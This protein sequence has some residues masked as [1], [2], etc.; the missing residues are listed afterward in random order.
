MTEKE[1]E[2]I[3]NIKLIAEFDGWKVNCFSERIVPAEW[4]EKMINGSVCSYQ[5]RKLDG[6]ID[7]HLLDM[8][9]HSS[10]NWIMAVVE[11]IESLG[12]YNVI[13]KLR[14]Q[15]HRVYF[16][17]KNYVEYAK[18]DRDENKR[19]A[20]YLAVIDFIKYWNDE[21]AKS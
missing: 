7:N 16:L 6:T 5:Y 10:F 19:T 14:S 1:I 20:V 8:K 4:I 12:F 9:Y 18:G 13:E 17:D 15:E 2:T 21:K 11:K 3:E